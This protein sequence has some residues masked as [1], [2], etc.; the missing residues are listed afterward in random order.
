MRD[1]RSQPTKDGLH[2]QQGIGTETQKQGA[3]PNKQA[4]H[5]E[6]GLGRSSPRSGT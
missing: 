4:D 1:S 2:F 3:K 6:Y 5:V